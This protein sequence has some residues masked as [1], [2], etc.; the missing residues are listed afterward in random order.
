[1]FPNARIIHC[2][3]NPL[4]SCLS[5][6]FQ[7]FFQRMDWCYDQKNLAA[8]YRGYEK[9]MNHWK[10]VLNIQIMDVSYEELVSDQENISRKLIEFCDLD[11]TD[12]WLQ[13]HKTKRF[14]ATASYDQVRRPIYKKSVARWKNYEQHIGIL[15][16]ELDGYL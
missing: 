13:F 9:L 2:M 4:D 1:M 12:E 15:I 6:Y 16:K 10:Q 5:C 3:R 7:D 8:Y 11:W 14:V